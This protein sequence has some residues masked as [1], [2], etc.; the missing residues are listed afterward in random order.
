MKVFVNNEE[1]DYEE[2]VTLDILVSDY[3]GN[4]KISHVGAWVNNKMVRPVSYQQTVIQE[5][6][7]VVIRRFSAGG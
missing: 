2:G 3:K 1:K 5:N 6:D 4:Q 7:I